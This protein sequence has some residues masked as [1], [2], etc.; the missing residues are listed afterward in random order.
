MALRLETTTNVPLFVYAQSCL[1]LYD[2]GLFKMCLH[3]QALFK[4]LDKNITETPKPMV[5]IQYWES[6]NNIEQRKKYILTAL[7]HFS[8]FQ[9]RLYFSRR[10]VTWIPKAKCKMKFNYLTQQVLDLTQ[11][12]QKL[13]HVMKQ[14]ARVRIAA[15]RLALAMSLHDRLGSASGIQILGSDLLA[16]IS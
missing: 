12:V 3:S 5:E 4:T 14:W 13:Q 6:A 11:Q 10:R 1:A 8:T 15:R 9:R 16:H 2:N 7:F